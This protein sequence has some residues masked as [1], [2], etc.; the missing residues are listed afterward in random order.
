MKKS[1]LKSVLLLAFAALTS[2]KTTQVA[3][4]ASIESLQ[5]IKLNSS[6]DDV[7]SVLGSKPYNILSSQIDSYTIYTYRYKLIERKVNPAIINSKGGETVGAEVYNGKEQTL[8]LFF[9]ANK[10]DGLV[11]TEGRKDSPAMVMLNNTLYTISKDREKYII[12]P[13]STDEY[14]SVDTNP[15]SKKRKS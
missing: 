5:Q 12:L 1:I 8:F 13:T 2:C 9:K 6:L 10:L 4:F 11:T 3:K 7:I 14:K 15:F